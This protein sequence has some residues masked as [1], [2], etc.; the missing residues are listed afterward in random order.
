VLI[1]ESGV[2]AER[3]GPVYYVGHIAWWEKVWYF[4]AERALPMAGATVLLILLITVFI[5]KLLRKRAHR[6]LRH[7]S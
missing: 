5:W 7:E 4:L 3:V 1:R 6:R 2:S